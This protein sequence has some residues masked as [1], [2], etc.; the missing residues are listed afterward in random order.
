[1]VRVAVIARPKTLSGSPELQVSSILF[2][3]IMVPIIE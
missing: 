3:D 2:G 1:M